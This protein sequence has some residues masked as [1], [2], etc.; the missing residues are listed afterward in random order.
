MTSPVIWPP[1][2]DAVVAAPDHHRVLLENA[3]VRVLDTR[4]GA[5]ARTPIHTHQWPAVHYVL[6]WSD[7]VR[8][9]DTGAVLVDTRT[10]APAS[11]HTALW[12]AP[13]AAHSLENVG[14]GPLHI[15]SVEM[16]PP[17]PAPP[18]EVG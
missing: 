4:I 13:L 2:L 11:V 1:E 16:K 17:R 10:S 9:D 14:S 5:G 3:Q 6:A 7:F 18:G 15:I 8:R 12:G